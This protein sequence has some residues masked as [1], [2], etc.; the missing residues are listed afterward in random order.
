MSIRFCFSSQWPF[1]VAIARTS[2]GIRDQRVSPALVHVKRKFCLLLPAAKCD[3]SPL[4]FKKCYFGEPCRLLF[5]VSRYAACHSGRHRTRAAE[6]RTVLTCKHS[7]C[8]LLCFPVTGIDISLQPIRYFSWNL[9]CNLTQLL[10]N[11]ITS[12]VNTL[13]S[14][15]RYLHESVTIELSILLTGPHL[16]TVLTS[17]SDKK[18]CP[19]TCSFSFRKGWSDG[20]KSG[21]YVGWSKTVKQRRWICSIVRALVWDL[22]LLY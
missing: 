17:S 21:H 9:F 13:P 5:V 1:V 6:H 2:L 11:I 15:F 10:L 18:W 8:I 12:A 14:T 7:W 19:L 22:T 20:A 16:T 4:S 3:H